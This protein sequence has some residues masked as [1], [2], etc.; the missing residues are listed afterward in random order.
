MGGKKKKGRLNTPVSSPQIPQDYDLQ[1]ALSV[2]RRGGKNIVEPVESTKTDI[3]IGSVIVNVPDK[4]I[5]YNT[6]TLSQ[7]TSNFATEQYVESLVNNL[8]ADQKTSNTQLTESFNIKISAINN[9]IDEIKDKCLSKSGFWTG[10]TIVIAIIGL[11][12]AF[13]LHDIQK[14]QKQIENI[15][16]TVNS[17]NKKIEALEEDITSFRDSITVIQEEVTIRNNKK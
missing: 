17:Q 4:S 8:K 7:P 10:I 1:H 2:I 12:V 3:R 14:P 16:N 13:L 6:E 15:S 9:R 5:D 11:V